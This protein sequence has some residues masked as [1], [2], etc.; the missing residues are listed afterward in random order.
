MEKEH[1]EQP[2]I[3]LFLFIGLLFGGLLREINKK[4]KFPY[5]PLLI[6]LG[7]IMGIYKD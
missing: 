3:L 2:L 5:T 6:I 4:T 1:H 7:I